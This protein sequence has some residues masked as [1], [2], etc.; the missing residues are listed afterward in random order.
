MVAYQYRDYT[1]DLGRQRYEVY[2]PDGNQFAGCA[3]PH[4]LDPKKEAEEMVDQ[5]IQITKLEL[6]AM[7]KEIEDENDSAP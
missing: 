7:I 2:Y 3:G 4:I 6:K 5:H 1:I